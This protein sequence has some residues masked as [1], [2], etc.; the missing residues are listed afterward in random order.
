MRQCYVCR[1]GSF[2][3]VKG[4]VRDLPRMPIM[5][6]T[7][8]GLI[9]LADFSHIDDR[10]YAESR[11]R[12]GEAIL[13]WK[14]YLAE[15]L[16]DDARRAAWMEDDVRGKSVL[17]FGCGAGGFLARIKKYARHLAGVEKDTALQAIIGKKFKIP[18]YADM[19][20]V[21]EKFDVVTLFHVLEHFK[22]PRAILRSIAGHVS[23]RGRIIIEVP[24]ADDA[25]LSLF[26]CKAFS[27][28]T[29]WGC[30]L[31]LFNRKNL[32]LLLKSA[33]LKVTYIKQIQRYPL[34]NHLYWLSRGKP[35][36]HNVWGSLESPGLR[37][38][39]ERS[40]AQQGICDTL[41]AQAAG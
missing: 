33:G 4:K 35:G 15:C 23:R 19:N 30:H 26:E 24:N 32:L 3:R 13:D 16:P 11:M 31:Y 10:F 22:D 41:I 25:L 17:D 9:F 14:R 36:G 37:Q 20:E 21:E 39:Y 34:S 5:K 1:S 18:V 8:C 6:C 2:V 27:E 7:Q 12:K 29:F 38:A 28:F 40:L